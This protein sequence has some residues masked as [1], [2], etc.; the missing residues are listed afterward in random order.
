MYSE[1]ELLVIAENLEQG[2]EIAVETEEGE[3][4]NM[5]IVTWS[6]TRIKL[7]TKSGDIVFFDPESLEEFDGTMVISGEKLS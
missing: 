2:D 3:T 7:K 6:K 4:H 5:I 1:W